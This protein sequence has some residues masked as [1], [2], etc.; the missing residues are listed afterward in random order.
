MN[1]EEWYL[2]QVKTVVEKNRFAPYT[3]KSYYDLAKSIKNSLKR[4]RILP[5]NNIEFERK[6]NFG[7]LKHTRLSLAKIVDITKFY[8]RSLEVDYD[9]FHKEFKSNRHFYN[10]EYMKSGQNGIVSYNQ[11]FY[12][13]FTKAHNECNRLFKQH[14]E[15]IKNQEN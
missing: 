12:N 6:I 8:F 7:V 11:W 1:Y 2:E 5:Q 9:E 3:N 10:F 13:E 15:E 4:Q 14:L